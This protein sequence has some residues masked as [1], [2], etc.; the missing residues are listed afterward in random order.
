V[1]IASLDLDA[2]ASFRAGM[3]FFRD[4]RPELYAPLLTRDGRVKKGGG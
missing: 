3:G 2:A 1:L 4:W